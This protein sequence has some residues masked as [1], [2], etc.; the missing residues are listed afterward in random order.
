MVSGIEC[1]LLFISSSTRVGLVVC[2]RAIEISP[3]SS[4]TR[5]AIVRRCAAE[6]SRNSGVKFSFAIA[7]N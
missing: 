3:K 7:S 1:L 6:R 4:C 2:S 5:V